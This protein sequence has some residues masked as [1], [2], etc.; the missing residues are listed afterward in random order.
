MGAK[1]WMLVTAEENARVSWRTFSTLNREASV[2]FAHEL[3]PEEIHTPLMMVICT[4]RIHLDEL[5]WDAL[6]A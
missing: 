3:F 2:H 5:S 1:T 4:I 6:R